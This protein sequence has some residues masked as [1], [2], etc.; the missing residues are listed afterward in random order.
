M[1][2]N[3][4]MQEHMLTP[5]DIKKSLSSSIP[6][7]GKQQIK[8][9]PDWS[10]FINNINTASK[11]TSV[12]GKAPY[13]NF[14]RINHVRFYNKLTFGIDYSDRYPYAG[15]EEMKEYIRSLGL[16]PFV[17]MSFMGLS[18]SQS[19]TGRHCDQCSIMYIQAVNSVKWV[20]VC[21]GVEMEYILDP[22]DV[23]FIPEGL[24][25]EIFSFMPRAGLSFAV[26]LIS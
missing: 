11:E 4:Y 16:D 21:D 22:G 8:T 24:F 26:R 5:D 3:R 14:D 20:V 10:D 18:D 7:Y 12:V 1:Q 17:T 9:L 6:V 13:E 19:T 2:Y 23:L 15:L 25:H